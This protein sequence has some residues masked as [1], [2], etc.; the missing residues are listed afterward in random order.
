MANVL[1]IG[2][3]FDDLELGCG[4]SL[5]RHVRDGDTVTM[6]VVS[7][8]GY[9]NPQGTV[10]RDQDVALQEG[11]AAAQ[12][13]GADLLTFNDKTLGLQFDEV[14]TARLLAVIEQ[15]AIDTVYTHWIHDIHRDHQNVGKATL[16]AARHVPRLLMYRSN[17][18]SGGEPFRG[19]HFTDV[20][21]TWSIKTK[22]IEAHASEI[23][24]VGRSWLDNVEHQAALDGQTI[25]VAHAECFEVVRYAT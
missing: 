21:E 15:R 24:R 12:L 20:S 19:T 11:E 16:M 6:L 14:L 7:H 22:A 17:A 5:A 25:G 4:G 9:A 13:I 2:A 23:A 18:Y 3:H 10:V 8:S 1:G